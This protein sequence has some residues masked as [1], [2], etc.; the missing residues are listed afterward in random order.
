MANLPATIFSRLEGKSVDLRRYSLS[1]NPRERGMPLYKK[2]SGKRRNWPDEIESR[3]GANNPKGIAT[4]SPRLRGT[5]YLGK[6]AKQNASLPLEV[7]EIASA[8]LQ[9]EVGDAFQL[10]YPFC[11]RDGAPESREQMHVVFHSPGEDGRTIELF[12]DTAEI[13]VERVARGFVA[14][15]RTTVFGGEAEMN[16]NGGKGLWHVERM[17]SRVLVCQ[18]QRIASIRRRLARR[19]RPWV[20]IRKEPQR[21]RRC[22]RAQVR[23]RERSGRN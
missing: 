7:G 12:R 13:R 15:K 2:L 6:T 9:P 17:V 3:S 18:S 5:S 16:V 14:Q 23:G 10:L 19:L 20:G 11:L 4:S 8:F 22:G 21:Q 1:S